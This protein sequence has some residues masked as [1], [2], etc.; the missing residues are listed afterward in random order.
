MTLSN[1]SDIIDLSNDS[2]RVYYLGMYPKVL[3]WGKSVKCP[4]KI[5]VV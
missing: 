5:I 1:I 2:V 3:K 4:E